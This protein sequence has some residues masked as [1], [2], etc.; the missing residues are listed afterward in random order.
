MAREDYE[1]DDDRYEGRSE[2]RFGRGGNGG[3]RA[4]WSSGSRRQGS[5]RESRTGARD[6]GRE[7][8]DWARG[9]ERTRDTGYGYGTGEHGTQQWGEGRWDDQDREYRERTIDRCCSAA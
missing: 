8:Q 2:R 6:Y 1:R 5:G 7:Q 3:E 4:D 9:S